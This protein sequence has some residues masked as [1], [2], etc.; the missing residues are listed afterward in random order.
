MQ[1]NNNKIIFNSSPLINLAKINSLSLIENLFDQIIIPPAVRIEVIEQARNIDESSDIKQLI[2][3][4]IIIIKQIQNQTLVKSFQSHLD[5]GE[6]EVI[7]LA[8]E[9]NADLVVIDEMQARETADIYNL[10]KTGFLGIIL[11]AEREN[12]IDS[13]L[14][15]I[16]RAIDQG[17]YIDDSLYEK[18]V[19][20]LSEL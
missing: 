7:A 1:K 18:L 14:D 11:K 20:Q 9:I 17:F 6:S 4:N 3:D 8:L 13:D 15:L 10:N 2:Q 12:V 5:F 16:D 19:Q